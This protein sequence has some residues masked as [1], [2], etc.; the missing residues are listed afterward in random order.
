MKRST[1]YAPK[2]KVFAG[3][4]SLHN[5]ITFAVGINSLGVEVF[6]KRLFKKLGI[7]LTP[8]VAYY[9][10]T[11]EKSRVKRLESIGTRAAKQKKNKR[12][13]DKL[14]DATLQAKK[15]FLKR[16][17][18]YR[19]GM[20][21]D[22]PFGELLNGVEDEEDDAGNKKPPA[23][24][25]KAKATGFCEYCGKSDHL[26]KCSKKCSALLDSAK[27]FRRQDGSSLLT[28]PPAATILVPDEADNTGA[29]APDLNCLLAAAAMP[30]TL[31][32]NDAAAV[33]CDSFDSLPWNTAL[34]DN[35]SEAGSV[36]FQDAHTWDTDDDSEDG[37][38]DCMI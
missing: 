31:D 36:D 25:N 26:T 29:P 18:T 10:H 34:S 38:I 27:R 20:N 16:Q 14:K 9:L 37:N 5:R 6:F 7:K 8:N 19:K 2:N 22:D 17:G 4:G 28:D 33:D 15:E 21:I 30:P 3:S 11:R 23:K 32:N 12:K 35:E 1:K 24:R 13:Y